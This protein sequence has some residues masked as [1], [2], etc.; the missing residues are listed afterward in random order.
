MNH[1]RRPDG[2]DESA[3]EKDVGK[4]QGHQPIQVAGTIYETLTR[5]QS[6]GRLM[7]GACYGSTRK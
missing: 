7:A 4:G 5:W 6:E 2:S 3:I 1:L